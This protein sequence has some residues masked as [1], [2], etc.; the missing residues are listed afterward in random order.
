[1]SSVHREEQP[2]PGAVSVA[3]VYFT[4]AAVTHERA[5]EIAKMLSVTV[6]VT[7][8][9]KHSFKAA[10]CLVSVSSVNVGK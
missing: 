9:M 8:K 5:T 10:I 3:V 6:V 1:M 7:E 4:Y 2:C